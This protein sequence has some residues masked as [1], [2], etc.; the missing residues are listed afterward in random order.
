MTDNISE[1]TSS[2]EEGDSSQSP[3]AGG[4]N[5]SPGSQL[6]RAREDAGLSRKAL[7]DRLCM[8]G[9]KL[10]LLETDQY[11]RLPG[12]LYVRGYFR[13]ACK[14]LG[15]DPKPLLDAFSGYS[16]VETESRDIL[17]H[18][19]RGP[20]FTQ[21]RRGLSWLAL[22]PLL[23]VGGVFWG[24]YGRDA[25]PPAFIADLSASDSDAVPAAPESRQPE[26]F[27]VG[28]DEEPEGDETQ[29]FEYRGEAD[30]TPVG[31]Q[32]QAVEPGAAAEPQPA[33]EGELQLIFDEEAWV[34]VRDAAGKVLLAKLRPA[35]S[36]S[37]LAGQP[38]F[39]L[40]LGNASATRVRYKGELIDSAPI[41]NRRTRRVIVGD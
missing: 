12:A 20:E 17:A 3:P 15:I 38:P 19:S 24:M 11:D 1:I 29:L 7:S 32:V 25:A 40:M 14:E 33:L 21:R 28:P 37:R 8:I 27:E 26:V 13:G 31:S 41:G 6:R 39:E 16:T 10:E 4:L 2:N 9:N 22:L 5:D 35:G 18:V 34:E 23:L 36:E 30:T